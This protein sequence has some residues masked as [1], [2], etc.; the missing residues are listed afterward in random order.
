MRKCIISTAF[1]LLS[2][3]FI[4]C[5][6]EPTVSDF[7]NNQGNV[8]KGG[9][10]GGGETTTG[11]NLS[12]PVLLADGFSLTKLFTSSFTAPYTG[13]YPGITDPAEINYLNT[14][15]PWYAQKTSGNVWQADFETVTSVGVSFIDWGD[16]IE[17]VDPKVG[18]PYRLELS[19]YNKHDHDMTAYKMAVLEYPSSSSELQGTNTKTFSSS[20]PSVISSRGALLVQKFA[21]GAILTWNG[22]QW[23]GTGVDNPTSISF[24][25]ELNVGGK[26]IFGAS[27]GGW[28]PASKGNYRITFYLPG[29]GV[30]LK[31]AIIADFENPETSKTAEN[32]QPFVDSI[33]NLTYVDVQVT[34]G[35]GSG[36]SG[37]RGGSGNNGSNGGNGGS[38][39]SGGKRGR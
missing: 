4:Q 11:N 19:I 8:T 18:I 26:Y 22:C 21:D 3:F 33:N 35:S 38:G 28:V 1:V 7:A 24:A 10:P 39:G 17:S 34:S 20:Y 25:P 12:Y 23:T 13:T 14:N 29:S 37:G 30:N 36:G 27:T 2:L 31:E 6:E 32:N 9:T 16:A 5:N 15:K